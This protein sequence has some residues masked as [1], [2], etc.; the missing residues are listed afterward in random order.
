[1]KKRN[2]T[3]ARDRKH[4]YA[5]QRD[6]RKRSRIARHR[7]VYPRSWR[8]DIAAAAGRM[9]PSPGMPGFAPEPGFFRA[10]WRLVVALLQRFKRRRPV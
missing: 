2:A 9:K 5:T 1:M 4:W 7:R 10:C 3:R 8:R 6:Q